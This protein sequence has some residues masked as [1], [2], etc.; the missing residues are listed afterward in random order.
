MLKEDNKVSVWIKKKSRTGK[1]LS[2]LEEFNNLVYYLM[3]TYN[4][5]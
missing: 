5:K 2:P 3:D 1:I 4:T